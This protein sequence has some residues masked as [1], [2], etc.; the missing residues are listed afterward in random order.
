[1][2]WYKTNEEL[3]R[4]YSA[5]DTSYI[6]DPKLKIEEK[7][8]S[9]TIIIQNIYKSI[10]EKKRKRKAINRWEK[11]KRSTNKTTFQFPKEINSKLYAWRNKRT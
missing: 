11:N 3:L 7:T 6:D 2:N 5:I 9:L 4:D 10:P 1:M 8:N